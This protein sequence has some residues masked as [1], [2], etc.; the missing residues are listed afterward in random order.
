MFSW[1]STL[2]TLRPTMPLML[3]SALS[4]ATYTML[5]MLC[6]R[7][8]LELS[9]TL[10]MLRDQLSLQT[11]NTLLTLLSLSLSCLFFQ[12]ALAFS[13][14][15]TSRSLFIPRSYNL[16]FSRNYQDALDATLLA[17][18]WNFQHAPDSAL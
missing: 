15:R 17:R 9:N 12:Q 1:N 2:L 18:P 4:C 14:L 8:S 5:L 10:L 3:R 11:A 7:L 16:S 6:P 13:L